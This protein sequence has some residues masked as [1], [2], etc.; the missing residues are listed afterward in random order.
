MPANHTSDR[1]RADLL[2]DELIAT[3]E[4][5]DQAERLLTV[6]YEQQITED[7]QLGRGRADAC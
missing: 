5:R 3:R 7:E 6:F 1:E 4:Q 2:L